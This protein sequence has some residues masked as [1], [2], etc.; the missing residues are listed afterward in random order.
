MPL[1]DYEQAARFFRHKDFVFDRET[2]TYRCPQGTTLTFRGN[3]Y[4]TRVRS[5]AA[6]T[7]VCAVCPVRARCTDST[8]GRR[9]N[10]PFDEEYRERARALEGTAV[11]QKAMRKRQVWVEPLFGEAKQWHGLRHFRLR[12]LWRVNTEALLIAAGQNLKR[13]LRTTGWGRRNGPA[14]S[15]ALSRH[16]C[17]ACS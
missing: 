7:A 13:W 4:V 5:Y 14:G 6:P 11:Y 1:V 2:D 10:R 15:L 9:I 3:N 17:V 12:R 16:V 8:G